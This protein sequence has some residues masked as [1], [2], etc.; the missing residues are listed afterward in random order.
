MTIKE[1][2]DMIDS[3]G[4]HLEGLDLLYAYLAHD[5]FDYTSYDDGL[6]IEMGK[7]L[8]R[9]VDAILKKEQRCLV[10][11]DFYEDYIMCLNIMQLNC[12]KINW[13]TS[14]RF[15]WFEY[16]EDGYWSKE[17]YDCMISTYNSIVKLLKGE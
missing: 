7:K 15:P 3:Q 8:F 9:T 14:I 12:Q 17:D 5:I 10:N 13:G 1:Y 6:D 2:S 16:D 11:S 4:G